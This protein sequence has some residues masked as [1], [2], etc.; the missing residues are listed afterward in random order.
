MTILGVT[1]EDD[2][3]VHQHID[4]LC[5]AAGQNLFALKTL[6]AHGASK[7]ML[8]QV[9]Q[10]TLVNRITYASPAWRGFASAADLGRLDAIFARAKRWGLLKAFAPH[11]QE[12]MDK[13]DTTLFSK[14]L[15][16]N[17]HV[18]HNLLPSIKTTAYS[19][20][21]RSHNRQ[22]P[23]KSNSSIRNFIDR[24]LYSF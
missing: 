12:S 8:H 24:M 13:I 9:C 5:A 10:A 23:V 21:P 3:H 6:K 15:A 22:L 18:L 16:N 14:V 2:L 1:I 17:F 4:N 19:L 11:V 20:R 7:D